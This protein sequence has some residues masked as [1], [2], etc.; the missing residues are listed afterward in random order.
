MRRRSWR[1]ASAGVLALMLLAFA[2][3]DVGRA[4]AGNQAPARN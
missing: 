1:V 4:E 2:A 3:A